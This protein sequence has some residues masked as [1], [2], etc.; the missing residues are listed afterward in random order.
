MECRQILGIGLF[1]PLIIRCLWHLLERLRS[2]HLVIYLHGI[3]SEPRYLGNGGPGPGSGKGLSE[4]L[5]F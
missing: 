5:N 2:L 3:L 1:C 4:I